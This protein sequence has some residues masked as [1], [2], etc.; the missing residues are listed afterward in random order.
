MKTK[1]K[2]LVLPNGCW[3]WQA[4]KDKDGYGVAW[5]GE[6]V[7][8]HRLYYSN[9]V[10]EIR[11]T[12]VID[13]LCRNRACVNPSHLEAVNVATN[14]QRGENAKIS[15]QSVLII[16]DLYKK[17]MKQLDLASNFGLTQSGISLI[18]NNKTWINI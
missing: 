7:R 18:V 11:S 13:H 3:E 14:T 6:S 17:G 9:F 1:E 16:R 4:A 15:A 2:Y 5:N 12:E 8:A 10:R